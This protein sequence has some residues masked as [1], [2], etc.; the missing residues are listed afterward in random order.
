MSIDNTHRPPAAGTD[1]DASPT[2]SD[3]VDAFSSVPS[4]M[5]EPYAHGSAPKPAAHETADA[6]TEDTFTASPDIDDEHESAPFPSTPDGDFGFSSS[7]P[8]HDE[9]APADVPD[10]SPKAGDGP[11]SEPAD[12]D[13]TLFTTPTPDTAPGYDDRQPQS[14]SAEAP[15]APIVVAPDGTARFEVKS[16]APKPVPGT[17]PSSGAES[18]PPKSSPE[19]AEKKSWSFRKEKS[20]KPQG[21]AKTTKTPRPQVVFPAFSRTHPV[22]GVEEKLPPSV[23]SRLFKALALFPLLPLT[24]LLCLQVV[25]CLDARSFWTGTEVFFADAFHNLLGGKGLPVEVNGKAVLASSP[26]YFWFLRGVYELV[27][28]EGPLLHFAGAAVSALAYLWAALCLGRMAARV[29]GR[30]NL[31][32]GI[33]LLSCAFLTGALHRAQA[34][35]L[36]AALLVS[37]LVAIYRAQVS[38]KQR[39]LLML[40]GFVCTGAASLMSGPFVLALPVLASALFAVWRADG[41]QVRCL[42]ISTLALLCGLAPFFA[43]APLL[44]HFGFIQAGEALPPA[45]S[46]G[47]LFPPLLALLLCWRFLPA[48]RLCILLSAA[49]MIAAFILSGAASIAVPPLEHS[50]LILAAALLVLWQVTPQRLFRT[51]FV[52]GL[53]MGLATAA[54]WFGFIYLQS[55]DQALALSTFFAHFPPMAA[56]PPAAWLSATVF[57]AALFLPWTLSLFCLPINRLFGKNMREALAASRRPEKEGLAFLFCIIAAALAL[58]GLPGDTSRLMLP[59]ALPALALITA[60]AVL[61]LGPRGASL[62]RYGMAVFLA[63]AAVV[64]LVVSLMLFGYLSMPDI[65]GLPQWRLPSG[66]GFFLIAAVLLLSAALLWVGL[67]SARP[68][69]VLLIMA[70]CAAGLGFPLGGLALP[71]FDS[72]LS[73]RD[74]GLLM[75]AYVEKGYTPAAFAIPGATYSFFAGKTV[76]EAASLEAAAELAQ[77]GNLIL[78]M[79]LEAWTAWENKPE[80]LQEVQQQWLGK[81]QCVLLA[82]PP[83]EGLAPAEDPSGRSP[84]LVQRVKGLLGREDGMADE[85][86]ATPKTAP[87]SKPPAPAA[88]V[89]PA[90][91]ASDANALP[92]SEEASTPPASDA[93]SEPGPDAQKEMPQSTAESAENAP[94]AQPAMQD[95]TVT[96]PDASTPIPDAVGTPTDDPAPTAPLSAPDADPAATDGAAPGGADGAP[97]SAE[98]APNAAPASLT[99]GDAPSAAPEPEIP[100]KKPAAPPEEGQPED[101]VEKEGERATGQSAPATDAQA[102]EEAGQKT[103]NASVQ[104]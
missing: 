6:Q 32:A 18:A 89:Q 50:L 34:D 35:L 56:H 73:P 82:C 67:S 99:S 4:Y 88:D 51:D 104:E 100:V 12:T 28:T 49:L 53:L 85:P 24:A 38:P 25:F 91:E 78:A 77:T 39:P 54:S 10:S 64:I 13:A 40:T 20:A 26:L 7:V 62:L 75:R 36:I 41:D 97:N 1:A 70:L 31:A 96:P 61:G 30:G 22:L 58:L 84:D 46:A 44:A 93:Q 3:E 76:A 16:D 21:T 27:P 14:E 86:A 95:E 15:S 94:P 74:Q 71:N 45:W 79:P 90:A 33:V 29:D 63:L 60:R 101:A 65:A 55:G 52:F 23:G 102:E 69:G 98:N 68:E 92:E 11:E 81:R 43:G 80:G 83:L 17:P 42:C 48:V 87:V 66:G 59:A 72:A 103:G 2:H 5:R 37:G 19:K 8:P 9:S 57:L 47:L